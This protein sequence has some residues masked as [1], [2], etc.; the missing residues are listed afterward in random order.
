MLRQTDIASHQLKPENMLQLFPSEPRPESFDGIWAP[1]VT[2]FKDGEIDHEALALLAQFLTSKGIRGLLVAGTTGEIHSLSLRERLN[3]VRTV[4]TATDGLVPILIGIREGDVTANSRE[5]AQFNLPIAG[6]VLPVPEFEQNGFRNGGRRL[7]NHCLAAADATDRPIILYD[8]HR[9][10]GQGLTPEIMATLH[11]TGR[12]PAVVLDGRGVELLPEMV[13]MNGPN[14]LSGSEKW[15]F[16]TLQLGGHGGMLPMAN[17][18]PEMLV[19]THD[20]FMAGQHDA[21]WN[22]YRSMRGLYKRFSGQTRIS[23]LKT[24]LAFDHVI[25]AEVRA[26]EPEVHPSETLRI[27]SELHAL[28]SGNIAA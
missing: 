24:V 13:S 5:I 2:P 12:F 4:V 9:R 8:R 15:L 19:R 21:A 10:T 23:A 3:A 26:P 1:L 6:F 18:I 14:I 16:I 17:L 7:I 27:R 22:L 11:Q 20:L 25:S 28:R